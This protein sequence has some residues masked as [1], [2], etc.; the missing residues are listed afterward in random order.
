VIGAIPD[1]DSQMGGPV[2][3][4]DDLDYH[5]FAQTVEHRRGNSC[6]YMGC[7]ECPSI[8]SMTI[9]GS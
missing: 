5:T 6:P 7:V 1:L 3:V 2:E 9:R 4:R 8:S